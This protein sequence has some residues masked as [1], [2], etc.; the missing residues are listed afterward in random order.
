LESGWLRSG[1]A[2]SLEEP[3]KN[4]QILDSLHLAQQKLVVVVL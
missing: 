1:Q 2:S 3:V 4:H